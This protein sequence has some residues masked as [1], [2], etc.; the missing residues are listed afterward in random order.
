MLRPLRSTCRHVTHLRRSRGYSVPSL[1]MDKQDGVKVTAC[2]SISRCPTYTQL[3]TLCA[4][5]CL[6][7]KLLVDLANVCLSAGSTSELHRLLFCRCFCWETFRCPHVSICAPVMSQF[8]ET[9]LRVASSAPIA[10]VGF[11]KCTLHSATS[12]CLMH[13]GCSYAKLLALSM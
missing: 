3:Y 12:L 9:V 4:A 13:L 1:E 6:K 10:Q 7:P 2:W 5:A 8:R 11:S